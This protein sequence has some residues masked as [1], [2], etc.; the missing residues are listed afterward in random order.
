M[1]AAER[2]AGTVGVTIAGPLSSALSNDISQP[3][4][5]ASVSTIIGA[6]LGTYAAI[7]YDEAHRP[8]GK[9]FALALATIIVAAAVTGVV[10]A[11]LGWGWASDKLAGG[12]AALAALA[13]YYWLPPAIQRSVEI[14]RGLK[15]A[16]LLPWRK[17]RTDKQ[18]P[19][20]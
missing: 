14:I 15:L 18:N 19:E 4:I 16:D 2:F 3:I 7:A 8:R 20:P 12:F 10:P 9:L 1:H 17:G 5:A 6:A 13:V 11:A